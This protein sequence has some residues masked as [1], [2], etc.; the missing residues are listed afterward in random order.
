MAVALGRTMVL[1]VL[2]LPRAVE[3]QDLVVAGL[4][5]MPCAVLVEG[6]RSR[7][8]HRMLG[9]VGDQVEIAVI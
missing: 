4:D 7:S 1:A 8:T 2:L 3:F 6:T 5:V 9:S